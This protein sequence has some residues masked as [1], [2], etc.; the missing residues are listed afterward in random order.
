MDSTLWSPKYKEDIFRKIPIGATKKEV[1]RGLGYPLQV[2][3]STSKIW[4]APGEGHPL[5]D[6]DL[7]K[8]DYWMYTSPGRK[9]GDSSYR[10]RAIIFD[11]HNRL[12]SKEICNVS[13]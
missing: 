7:L 13:D 8:A 10:L 2:H 4:P 12:M 5:T 3:L 11:S 6:E 1:L 9:L